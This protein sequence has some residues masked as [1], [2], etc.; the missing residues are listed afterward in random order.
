[1]QLKYAEI[2]LNEAK[3]VLGKNFVLLVTATDTETKI[4]HQNFTYFKSAILKLHHASSTYF[5]AKF[6]LYAV[7]HVQSKMGSISSG[8]TINTV[9][10]AIGLFNPDIT[11]MPG[12]CFG[13][14]EEKQSIG[15]LIIAEGIQP[16][17]F[18]RV[19]K[20]ST[21]IRAGSIQ[22]SSIL[23]NRI[24]NILTWEYINN[25][26]TQAKKI[27][28]ILLSGE[29]L[30][31]NRAYRDELVSTFPL[32]K[33][34]DMEGV[35]IHSACN[36]NCEWI[37]IKGICDFADGNKS[38]DKK[39]RQEIAMCS[40]VSLCLELFNSE[41]A[42]EFQGIV[43]FTQ[44]SSPPQKSN[45]FQSLFDFYIPQYE[46]WY[47]ERDIDKKIKN[48]LATKCTWIYGP[49]G[50]GKTTLLTRN[51]LQS[52]KRIIQINLASCVD[53]NVNE[54]VNEILF[55]LAFT[56]NKP[57]FLPASN[58]NRTSRQIIETLQKHNSEE[59]T[60]VY[61]D[62]I[63]LDEDEF[64]SEFRNKIFALIMQI[65][66]VP[67][68]RN[69]RFCFSSIFNP[70]IDL[71]DYQLKVRDYINFFDIGLW[72]RQ[73]ISNLLNLVIT[74]IPISLSDEFKTQ[75]IQ[76]SNGSPRILKRIIRN[77]LF[78]PDYSEEEIIRLSIN[79]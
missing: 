48:S 75:I 40:A 77:K 33:G 70:S 22:A 16:Y 78:V 24:R 43:P 25:E 50:S 61:I 47:L 1:M 65:S 10:S 44:S 23:S 63:P 66:I 46:K 19:S 67:E 42:F 76:A 74:G 64:F 8:A 6:G 11:I 27:H 34:G 21:Q 72:N 41:S 45:S 38:I 53:M 2:D 73:D 58:F 28:G 56:S 59:E 12:I 60:I 31:D 37:L 29:E 54:I 32:A 51:I 57:N 39:K 13:I 7:V 35:G 30:I 69:I 20:N 52:G 17:N 15:D 49:S 68:I 62:E 9:S 71:K 4:L 26:G 55:N 18:K 3:Q 79:D 36:G 5:I 14:D